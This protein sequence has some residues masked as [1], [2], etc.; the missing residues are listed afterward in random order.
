MDKDDLCPDVPGLVENHGC[1]DKDTDG[2]GVVDRLDKCPTVP[3]PKE[4]Q[5]C[6]WADRDGDGVPDNEDAC[7]TV[8]GPKENHGC[9]DSDRDGDGIPDR[10]DKC[11]DQPETFNGYQDEDGCPDKPATVVF[12][13]GAV[14]I[15]EKIFFEFNKSRILPKSY[16]L[17]ATVAKVLTLH[18]EVTKVRIEGHTDNIGTHEYN[19]TLSQARAEA[20]REHLISI[21]GLDGSKLSAQGFAF[22]RPIGDNK[23]A[24]GRA[25]NRRVEFIVI[26]KNGQP[27]TP[28]DQH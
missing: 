20:V 8:Y 27:V 5:G 10:L 14:E 22:D 13:G 23:T 2:D 6:P 7:P 4:N 1:P 17:L 28:A 9:P 19:M 21:N 16:M 18:P 3:G 12:T 24:K 15:K 11:P 26:E 25:K